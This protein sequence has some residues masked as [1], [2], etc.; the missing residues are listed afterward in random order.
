MQEKDLEIINEK[1]AC[2]FEK[3]GIKN[4]Y[5]TGAGNS[6]MS[7]YSVLHKTQ[8]LFLRNKTFKVIFKKHDIDVLSIHY[9]R[10][11]NNNDEHIGDYFK[12]NVT[13][14]EIYRFNRVDLK[15][16]D[17][18]AIE[19][20][21][22][23]LEEFYP[24]N[25]KMNHGFRDVV[26]EKNINLANILVYIG[27]TGSLLD[28][29]TRGGL[30]RVFSGFKRDFTSIEAILKEIQLNNRENG[31]NT[32]VYLV[33]IPKYLGLPVTD[34][35][36]N[37]KLKKIAEQ[38]ANVIYV[39][40]I[41]AK[42]YYPHKGF[43]VHL[44]EEEYLEYNKIIMEKIYNKY[45][46]TM[47]MINIDRK[48]YKLNKLLEV[49]LTEF[50]S[51]SNNENLNVLLNKLIKEFDL[52]SDTINK[53]MTY[54]NSLNNKSFEMIAKKI[55]DEIIWMTINYYTEM[56]NKEGINTQIFLNDIKKY[57]NN[58]LPYD[59]YYVGKDN[60]NKIK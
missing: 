10:C 44:N 4:F 20:D 42:L 59:F 32:Q 31:T 26:L 1:L 7:G 8:P 29:I 35:L 58:R 38:Y 28:N 53:I 50:I 47:A 41:T 16:P 34:I 43:D 11:Q 13:E 27:A 2:L 25:P 40:P 18:P 33:G 6:L 17:T 37:N 52:S 5:L 14:E 49:Y 56:L 55:F 19:M 30:P 36:I 57:L 60:I 46:S 48:L 23:K 22:N 21:D 51:D 3:H 45:L 24:K 39:E 15:K 9:A 12:N 54:I